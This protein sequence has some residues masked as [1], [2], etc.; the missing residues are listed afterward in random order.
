MS[1]TIDKTDKKVHLEVEHWDVNK[2]MI[3]FYK[4]IPIP[5]YIWR[6]VADSF[7][8]VDYNDAAA[9][10]TQGK[11]SEFLG[12]SANEMYHNMPEIIEDFNR[13][14]VEK[15]QIR[16]KMH[17]R[18]NTT[19]ENKYL[20]V[21]YAFLPPD[22]ISV[23][24]MDITDNKK[25]EEALQESWNEYRELVE[26]LPQTVFEIDL[27]GN[28]TFV[29][30]YGFE[31]F[32]YAREDLNKRINAYQLFL[33]EDRKRAQKNIERILK[34]EVSD[35]NEYTAL[36]KDGSTF[37]VN[38]Y[39]SP[40]V[41]D[42]KLLGL[43]GI[44]IDITKRKRAQ[45]A[46]KKANDDL[47]KRV[48]QRT[49][50]LSRI[51]EMLKMEIAERK[52][53]ENTLKKTHE[54]FCKAIENADGVPYRLLHD[55]GIYDLLGE[56]AEKLLGISPHEFSYKKWSELK[57]KVLVIDPQAPSDPVEYVQAYRRGEVKQYRTDVQI[58][59][60]T[61][62]NKWISD[63]AVP[64]KDEKT[65][66]VI[67]SL[68]ILHDIT[69]RKRVEEALRQNEERYRAVVEQSNECIFLV[70]VN[71]KYILEAN[72]TVQRLLG[73]T[74]KELQKLKIYNIDVHERE[75]IDHKIQDIIK[76]GHQLLGERRYRRKDGTLVSVEVSANLI[77]YSGKR[78]LCVVSRDITERK[79]AEK[80][81][82]ENILLKTQ[83]KETYK[84]DDVVCQSDAMTEITK[85][86]QKIAKTDLNVF[87]YG[88]TGTGKEMIA[89]NIFLLSNRR[90][91][92]FIPLD[93]VALPP[94]LLESE[95]FGFE[96]GA[97]TGA[98]KSK[99]GLLELA[100][101]GTLFLDE[102]LELQPELQVKLLRVLQELKFRRIGGRKMIDVDVRIISATNRNP[103]EAIKE[104]RLREDLYYR[105]NVV[106]I[107]MPPL[108]DRKDDIE[109]LVYQFIGE[110]CSSCPNEIKGISSDAL[111]CLKCY[112]WPGN[113]REL[114]NVIERTMSLAEG[115]TI[116]LEDLPEHIRENYNLFPAEYSQYI[117]LNEAKEIYL[118]LFYQKYFDKLIKRHENNLTKVADEAGISRKTLYNILR[119]IGIK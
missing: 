23:Y 39:S 103:E 94:T 45:E 71:T 47:E 18:L 86:V 53:A 16:R 55:T 25:A 44:A 59:T 48:M 61:G 83:F 38:I 52:Q 26:L 33:P 66:Q 27:E 2:E 14:F 21:T 109:L 95:I 3:G 93:C 113:V 5:T 58:V 49:A 100:H 110:I 96:K 57:K 51:N 107:F 40:V 116:N 1:T 101:G 115:D 50:D 4:Y 79:R 22:L 34:G 65:G 75:D 76:E 111:K 6:R 64:I 104:K 11:I 17:Y 32:G 69:K 31:C 67:G 13:C 97:F 88:E 78:V 87:I 10:I 82:Q 12:T 70:D 106:P 114:K 19:A 43:R 15:T 63:C 99:P 36:R 92:P 24:T 29:N 46:L 102:I 56:G 30:S 68:G 42:G 60:P 28:I 108:R 89:R 35:G 9:D 91:K 81:Q 119:K 98:I 8:L 77:S 41:R 7:L 85:Q 73:Y 37:P 118:T 112:N 80:I 105:L 74:A 54:I 20:A 62:E 90:D 117:K 84:L 72:L